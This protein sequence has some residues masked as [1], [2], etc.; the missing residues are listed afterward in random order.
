MVWEF[1]A[2]YDYLGW[3]GDRTKVNR[4]L[5]M[6]GPAWPL[7]E[8][9]LSTLFGEIDTMTMIEGGTTIGVSPNRVPYTLDKSIDHQSR[10]GYAL[11]LSRR[12]A[13]GKWALSPS[14]TYADHFELNPLPATTSLLVIFEALL[15]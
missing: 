2:Q 4:G 10:V 8:Y 1:R 15:Q 14:L 9:T 11:S 6:I 7:E 12:F 5:Y 13:F 3:D